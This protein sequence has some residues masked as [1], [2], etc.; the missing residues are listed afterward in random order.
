MLVRIQTN[1]IT[2][3]LQLGMENGTT[4]LGNHLVSSYK[5]KCMLIYVMV[6]FVCRLDW[7]TGCPDTWSDLVGLWGCFWMRLMPGEG[8]CCVMRMPCCVGIRPP[9]NSP[10]GI[11]LFPT[12]MRVSSLEQFL[13]PQLNHQMV[14]ARL[15]SYPQPLERPWTRIAQLSHTQIPESLKL[16]RYNEDSLL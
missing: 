5:T 3:V 13:P 16:V 7:A 2:C 15:T 8:S 4:T 6:N 12:A 10:W 1:W 11:V 14:A 9:A